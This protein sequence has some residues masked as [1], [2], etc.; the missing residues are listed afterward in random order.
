MWLNLLFANH[1]DRSGEPLKALECIE[2]GVEHT[3]TSIELQLCKARVL[4]HHGNAN[5]AAEIIDKARKMDLADRYHNTRCTIYMLRADQFERAE[6][7]VV[8]F[9]KEESTGQNNLHDM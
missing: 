9:T 7:V 6:K 3:P 8:L 5:E 4:K 2:K 1:F